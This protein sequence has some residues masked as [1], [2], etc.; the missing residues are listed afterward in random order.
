MESIT[1]VYLSG[2]NVQDDIFLKDLSAS[3]SWKRP[4]IIIHDSQHSEPADI[5]FQTKRISGHLS[6]A[7]VANVPVSGN[8][9][10][11]LKLEGSKYSIRKDLLQQWF[12]MAPALVTNALLD[13]GGKADLMLL[14]SDLK[15]QLSV[16]ELILFPDNPLS[17]L[18]AMAERIESKT[19]IAE[20]L[21]LYPEEQNVLNLAEALLPVHIRTARVYTRDPQN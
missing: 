9:R 14:L 6:E 19:R 3:F 12:Q 2:K 8:Q 4:V 1:L 16:Q 21:N 11:L 17:P 5:S 10:G 13:S 18:G 20:L 7:L 15:E